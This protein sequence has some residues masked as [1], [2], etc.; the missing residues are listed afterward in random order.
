MPERLRDSARRKIMAGLVVTPAAAF[1]DL[2]MDQCA[3]DRDGNGAHLL[4]ASGAGERRVVA[5]GM[6]CHSGD[7]EGSN[8]FQ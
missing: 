4:S 5:D 3:G 2:P 7:R 8:R 6:D 1:E